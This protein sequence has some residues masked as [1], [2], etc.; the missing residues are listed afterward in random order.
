MNESSIFLTSSTSQPEER[1]HSR[2]HA[3]TLLPYAAVVLKLLSDVLYHNDKEWSDLLTH[4]HNVRQHFAAIGLS[5]YLD[6][7]EGFAYLT[8]PDSMQDG[9][10]SIAGRLPR[11]VRRTRLSYQATLLCVLLRDELQRFDAHEPEQTRLILTR[12][13]IRDLLYDFYAERTDMLQVENKIN[14]TI[15]QVAQAGFLRHLT[16]SEQEQYEVR[17]ILKA[18]IS[19]DLLVEIHTSLAAHIETAGSEQAHEERP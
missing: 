14:G 18:K 6:E 15:T 11:L 3:S 16:N 8:Q 17:R 5:L 4:Q 12:P 7:A 10:E 2:P 1:G 19:A 9:D 13:Q